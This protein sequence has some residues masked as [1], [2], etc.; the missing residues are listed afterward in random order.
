MNTVRHFALV[1]LFFSTA[2]VKA[3]YH[4]SSAINPHDSS[5]QSKAFQ[6]EIVTLGLG[7]GIDMSGIG[8]NLQV[9]PVRGIGIF[10]G[11]GYAVAGIGTNIG[12][13]A[14]IVSP[15]KYKVVPYWLLTY[16]Y[17]G[18]V[19]TPGNSSQNRLFKGITTGVGLDLVS[20]R[21]RLGYFSFA[22]LIPFRHAE[23]QRYDLIPIGGSASY[24]FYLGESRGQ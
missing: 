19:V 13:K 18:A 23:A 8:A 21:K 7:I 3:Q 22:F 10:A 24:R 6:R 16:G 11:A 17:N 1:L 2:S 9:Y 5:G 4:G 12:V 15:D 20:Q 14:R